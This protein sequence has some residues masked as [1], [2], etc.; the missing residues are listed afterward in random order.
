MGGAE[1]FVCNAVKGHLEKNHINVQVL[2]FSPGHAVNLCH[3][4]GIATHVLPMSFKMRRPLQLLKVLVYIRKFIKLHNIQIV[5]STMP[6]AHIITFFSTLFLKITRIWFQHGP[7]GGPLDHIANFLPVDKIFFNSLYLQKEHLKMPFASRNLKKHK[8]IKL[9]IPQENLNQ[10]KISEIVQK[11]KTDKILL[12]SA[13]RI[14]SWKGFHLIIEAIAL[15]LKEQENLRDRIEYI[16]LGDYTREKDKAYFHQ[17]EK[18]INHYELKQNIHLL[19]KVFDLHHYYC[20]ADIFIHAS[21]IPEPFGLVVAESMK[22]NCFVIGSNQGGIA[23]ILVHQ[24]SGISFN[25]TINNPAKDLCQYLSQAIHLYKNEPATF[26]RMKA[27]AK[28]KIDKDYSIQQ[29][30]N[31]LEKEYLK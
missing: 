7:V 31:A 14:C 3:E 13:G 1:A 17:L 18:L 8:I 11:Y 6:Y 12:M 25:P 21:T 22:N 19:G 28:N 2:F 10:E 15:L 4:S 26:Q 5:H 24:Q 20:A 29:M 9:G 23:D 16:I 27:T 30:I